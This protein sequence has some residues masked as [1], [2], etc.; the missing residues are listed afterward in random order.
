MG[1]T[2]EIPDHNPEPR[3]QGHKTL[4]S[5]IFGDLSPSTYIRLGLFLLC[6]L[7]GIVVL[8]GRDQPIAYAVIATVVVTTVRLLRRN[9]DG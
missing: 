5:E 3:T 4:L 7:V 2:P 8:I 9:K 1:N 6:A